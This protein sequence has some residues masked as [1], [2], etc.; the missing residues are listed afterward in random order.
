VARQV[1]L[2]LSFFLVSSGGSAGLALSQALSGSIAG[3]ITDESGAMVPGA[4]VVIQTPDGKETSAISGADG[5]YVLNGLAPG[6]YSVEATVVGFRQTKPALV[7]VGSGAAALNISLAV[8]TNKQEITVQE[9]VGPVVSTDPAQ[10]AGAIVMHGDELAQLSDD[11]DDLQADLEALAGPAAGPNGGQIY[12]DGFSGGDAPLPSKEAIREVRVN[13]NPF[14]PE[15]DAI[16]FGR[17]E[18]L[19]KPGADKFRGG[20]YF[21]YG[22]AAMNSRNPYA[23]QKAPFDLKE[24]GGNVGGP[25]GKNAS[26]FTDVDKRNIDNGGII[27][28]IVLNPTTLAVVNPFN[29]VFSSPLRR[30]RSSSRLDYQLGK[31]NTLIFRYTFTRDEAAYA[32][33][34][35]FN[36]STQAYRSLA[37]EHAFEATETAVLSPKVINETHFQ[38]RHQNA[39]QT[40]NSTDPSLIV[41]NSF[42]GGGSSAGLHDYIHHHYEVQNYTSVTSGVHVWK[43]GIRLRAVD[44]QDTSMTNFNGTYTFGGAYAPVLGADNLPVVPGIVCVA[45]APSQGCETISSIEQYRRTLLFQ[46]MGL[47]AA[48]VRLLGGGATQFSINT[49]NPYVHA[50]GLDA[51]L[52]VGDDWKLRPNLTVSLGLRYETQDNISDH[53][54]WAPRLGFAWAPGKGTSGGQ[55]FVVRGGFGMF[56]DRFSEQNVLLAQRF[57]GISQQQYVVPNPDTFPNIPTA[58]LLQGFARIQ[59]VHTISSSMQAPYVIQSALGVERQLPL[60]TTVALNAIVTH[61]LHELLSRDINAPLPGTYRGIPGTGV[62]P[63]GN[64]GPILEMESAGLYNQRQMTV[65]INSQANSKI[66]VWGYYSLNFAKSNTDGVGWSPANQYDLA[67]EYGPAGNDVRNRGGFGGTFTGRWGLRLS[68]FVNLQSGRPFNIVTSQDVYGDTLLTA[69]PGIA[70]NASQPDV[71]STPYGLLDP[72]PTPGEAIL[73]RNY[74]RSPGQFNAN[75]RLSKTFGFGPERASSGPPAGG[76]TA[77]PLRRY[78]L[79]FAISARNVFNY[80]NRG[81]V[82]GNIN[83]P[84]FGESTQIAGGFGAFGGNSNNRRL[85]LQVRFSF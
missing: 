69:R 54:D 75:V 70:S 8:E 15:Y 2:F 71:L 41:S 7:T 32:G 21:N 56:Y 51:G 83:S 37:Q 73:P 68:P 49:G 80:V 28:A 1:V 47:P 66:S 64:V 39:T 33:A 43:F 84:F 60:H 22:D 46:Q 34:G 76:G 81:P 85:E 55:K 6:A 42:N 30:F 57:N 78:N 52:F 63:Y 72:N 74:G 27:N 44:I 36:L 50:G 82:V 5:K 4:K 3:T 38:F 53:A 31:S 24:F 9:T 16:G 67:A 77:T 65:N 23:P 61:G 18:I 40:P 11:P 17:I 26:F 12:V 45:S 35:N 25:A 13:Q 19:T 62:Y 58:A 10:N 29:Q 48:Q 20:S 79:I 14:S 59:T